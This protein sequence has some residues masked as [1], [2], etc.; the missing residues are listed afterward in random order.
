M[1]VLLACLPVLADSGAGSFRLQMVTAPPGGCC[2]A[3]PVCRVCSALCIA[4]GFAL[5]RG[6]A[7]AL[8]VG[9]QSSLLK[10]FVWLLRVRSLHC[11]L[12][13][14]KIFSLLLFSWTAPPCG[15]PVALCLA[16]VRCFFYTLLSL[17]LLLLPPLGTDGRR[18]DSEAEWDSPRP[19]PGTTVPLVRV[20][21][22]FLLNYT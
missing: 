18:T 19:A 11:S 9:P 4:S 2:P 20:K 22:S 12:G 7:G 21:G 10:D 17:W 3:N 6:E 14:P 8:A 1:I 16:W 13:A 5:P 15:L